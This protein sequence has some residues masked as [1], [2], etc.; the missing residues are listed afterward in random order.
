MPDN[1]TTVELRLTLKNRSNLTLLSHDF[2]IIILVIL[3]LIII[4]LLLIIIVV[5]LIIFTRSN[6]T[7]PPLPND[8][9]PSV[10]LSPAVLD[11]VCCYC[12]CHSYCY[13]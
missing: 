9:V 4:V 11:Q 12:H 6:S 2:V 8:L 7:Q 3:L 1:E 13:C 10:L 5:I